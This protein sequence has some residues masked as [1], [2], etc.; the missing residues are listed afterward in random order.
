[1]CLVMFDEIPMF[2]LMFGI[3]DLFDT[4]NLLYY[5]ILGWDLRCN[6]K[7]YVLWDMDGFDYQ[8]IQHV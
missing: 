5:E 4:L 3:E 2:M 7:F 1:M 6:T 8:R